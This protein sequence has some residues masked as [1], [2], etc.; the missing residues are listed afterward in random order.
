MD[1]KCFFSQKTDL[2]YLVKILLDI[3]VQTANNG[4]GKG[5]FE[6]NCDLAHSVWAH[7]DTSSAVRPQA[8]LLSFQQNKFGIINTINLKLHCPKM[9]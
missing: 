1:Q 5:F 9:S 2:K 6:K 4:N 8:T 7:E 3:F